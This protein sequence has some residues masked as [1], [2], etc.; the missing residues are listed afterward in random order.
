MENGMMNGVVRCQN[1][2]MLDVSGEIDGRYS[3]DVYGGL[4][5]E[6]ITIINFN[7][8]QLIN[9]RDEINHSLKEVK[10]CSN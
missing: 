8:E 4:D 7:E 2:T 1:F 6:H 5:Q 3:I 9:L 10:K